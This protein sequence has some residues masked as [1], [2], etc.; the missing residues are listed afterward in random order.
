MDS[1][2]MRPDSNEARRMRQFLEDLRSW[3]QKV[4]LVSFHSD[5]EL[6]V[7]H[8]LDSLMALKAPAARKAEART[9]DVGSGGGFPGFPLILARPGWSLTS[10]ESVKK[11]QVFLLEAAKHLCL[12]NIS[13]LAE[14]AEETARNPEHRETYDLAFC[15]A[16]GRLSTICELTL[17]F[18]RVGGTLL[19]HRGAEGSDET[20]QAADAIKELG[21]QPVNL[22]SYRLPL[23]D[24][25]RT[26]VSIEK[27]RPAPAQ[28]PRRAGLPAKRPL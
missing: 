16:V 12:F 22:S 9:V 24:K 10:I 8:L 14:R 28:Y 17:P 4:N 27:V 15:R 23:L 21:G 3:N 25:S 26:I 18:L 6:F 20:R 7:H 19:A 5:E 11:K 13:A 2:G 1:V